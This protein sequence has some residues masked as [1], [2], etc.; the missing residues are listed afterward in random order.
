MHVYP[1]AISS[2]GLCC[3]PHSLT[4]KRSPIQSFV[5][6]C[7]RPFGPMKA[8]IPA[9]SNEIQICKSWPLLLQMSLKLAFLQGICHG[10]LVECKLFS[11]SMC[12]QNLLCR[13]KSRGKSCSTPNKSSAE[14][15]EIKLHVHYTEWLQVS[16]SH[17]CKLY[18]NF[19]RFPS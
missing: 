17:W 16:T 19:P 9:I 7:R 5:C 15:M 2:L 10:H 6:S 12:I 13:K 1:F 11:K 8:K 4:K 3:L 18:T 14:I